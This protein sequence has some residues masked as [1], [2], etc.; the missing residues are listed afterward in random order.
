MIKKICSLATLMLLWNVAHAQIA[1]WLVYPEYDGI[2]FIEGKYMKV[3]SNGKIGLLDLLGKVVLPPSYDYMTEYKD[4]YA[5][6]YNG[7]KLSAIVDINGVLVDLGDV[8]YSVSP[9]DARFYDGY[10]LVRA[11]DGNFYYI[12]PKGQR[13]LGPYAKAFPFSEGYAS[14]R[15]YVNYQK[16]QT[17]T[18][19]NL[20]DTKGNSVIGI[21]K[22]DAIQ[23]MSSV[24]DDKAI[25]VFKNRYYTFFPSKNE[26]APLSID[27]TDSKKSAVQAIDKLVFVRPVEDGYVLDAKNGSFR[28]DDKM[29]LTRLELVG[30]DPITSVFPVDVPSEPSSPFTLIT[31]G[32]LYGIHY[33]A[34]ELLPPQFE[35]ITCLE[36]DFA[37]V[38][39][40]GKYGV[41]TIDRYNN[42]TFRLNNNENIGFNHQYHI[43]KLAVWLP[44][45]IKCSSA[46]VVSHSSDCEIQIESRVENE[47]VERNTLGYNC[48]LSIPKNLT[49]TLQTHEY[50]Y[51][52]K[53][54]GLISSLHAVSISEWY[55]KYYEVNL[56]NS[57][58]VVSSPTDTITVE[59]DL[60]KTEVARN[61]ESNY[62]KKVE[63]VAA[64]FP[65][66]PIL[67]KITE[68]HFSFQIFGI[69]QEKIM[70]SVRITE[71]GCPSIE[72]PFEMIFTKPEP[73]EENKE[74]T[75][76]IKAV[77]KKKVEKKVTSPILFE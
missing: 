20:I 60:I 39:S 45:Y 18:I 62:F 40:N 26:M 11:N 27:G 74:T 68:N 43:A 23:F 76:T 17:E 41:V 9:E 10:L 38:R 72:Y 31:D 56:S 73:T 12:N 75:V 3:L 47:N 6:L 8:D 51:S 66:Q 71:E 7:G 53:Y 64:N 77:R 14:V 69:D 35:E 5:L 59:F 25:A 57:N 37:V 67:T 16:S 48:R 50:H 44:S 52:L 2:E 32:N 42:F 30:N 1:K 63:V 55:V 28:F 61:D 49:D 15:E 65:E 13:V 21:D 46:S 22:L 4:G 19:Y 58:Y 36:N 33:G 70:F 54:D 24:Y 34:E 29:R